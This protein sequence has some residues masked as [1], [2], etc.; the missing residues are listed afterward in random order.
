MEILASDPLHRVTPACGNTGAVWAG[1]ALTGRVS[2]SIQTMFRLIFQKRESKHAKR[3]L[4]FL[5]H[6]SL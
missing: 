2:V 5:P 3:M 6:Y 4:I 1:A